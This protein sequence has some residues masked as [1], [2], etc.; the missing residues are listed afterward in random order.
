VK[1]S[2]GIWGLGASE[3]AFR[4]LLRV[5]PADFH[6]AYAVPAQELFRD[7]YTEAFR[8]SG[9]RG[10]LA[11]WPR[12][13]WDAL[14]HGMG[15]RWH[16]LRGRGLPRGPHARRPEL[17]RDGGGRGRAIFQDIRSSARSLARSP[18]FSLVVVITLALGIGANTT[19]FTLTNAVLFR[20]LNVEEPERIASVFTSYAGGDRFG[21]TSFPDFADLRRRNEVFTGLVAYSFSPMGLVG[22]DGPEVVLGQM[23]SWDYFSVLGAQAHIGRTFLPEEGATPGSHPVAILSY[24]SWLSR[25]GGDH[26]IVGSVV[27]IN[28]HPF[29]VV[30]VASEDFTGLSVLITP[31]VWVPL[32]MADWALPFPVNLQGRIDP[33]LYLAGRLKPGVGMTQAQAGLD[34]LSAGLR[35]EYPRLNAG[36]SLTA[37]PA[38]RTR[39]GPGITVDVAERFLVMLTGVVGLVL[40]IACFNVANLHMA[41]ATRRQ[42]EFALRVSLGASRW[43]VV[44]LLLMESLLLSVVAGVASLGLAALVAAVGS[45][46]QPVMSIPVL[47]DIGLD[48]RVFGC[49][50][51]LA[52]LTGMVFGLAP[53]LRLLRPTKATVLIRRNPLVGRSLKRARLQSSL[54]V[55]QVAV[56]LVLLVS[57]GLL[58]RSMQAMVSV[59]PGYDLHSGVVLPVNLAYSKYGDEEAQIFFRELAHRTESLAGVRAVALAAYV[60]LAEVHGRHD[61]TIEGY[62]RGAGEFMTVRRNMVGPR[63]LEVMGIT[64]ARGRGI[65][66]RDARDS[67][68]VAVV[69]ETMA[70]RFW[71][72]RDPIGGTVTADLGVPR[73]VVGVIEDGKYGRMDESPQ[74]YLMIPLS[75]SEPRASMNLIVET[76]ATPERMIPSLEGVVRELDPNLPMLGI[77]TMPEHLDTALSA[78][79]LPAAFVGVFGFFALMLAMVGVFGVM[80]LAVSRRMQEFGIRLALGA[81]SAAIVRMV[82]SHG[83]RTA[84]MGVGV[85]LLMALGVTR[86]LT[87]FLYEVSALDPVVFGSVSV[88]LVASVVAACYVPARW[89]A[90]VDPARTLRAE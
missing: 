20:P 88:A 69:N 13:G 24:G 72:G 71:L 84:L 67:E 89:A 23:V 28:D 21:I 25:F 51:L 86:V 38:V 66:Q 59:D 17:D 30:G 54:T 11:F 49:T 44:R 75:Q 70:R 80:S 29:T 33:W 90:K 3:R 76:Q 41:R 12:A 14:Y 50:A 15:E 37:V 6:D 42:G 40:L 58:V 34:V 45:A 32:M 82:L 55:A 62:E 2:D 81:E 57:A 36:K 7:R 68:P 47:L 26:E 18:G 87:G 56:S 77:R 16:A 35:S 73:T 22:N 9:R 64:V 60:P 83:L 31:E 65:D 48:G 5:F 52:L 46:L 4:V 61:V 39:I 27:R 85:G 74:P 8:R 63:Y 78:A 10:V 19:V 79:R 1:E 53:A 43:R